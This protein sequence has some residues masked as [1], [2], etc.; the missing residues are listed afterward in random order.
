MKSEPTPSEVKDI[1]A[2]KKNNLIL[3]ENPVLRYL[4]FSALYVSEGTPI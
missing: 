4:T 2:F 3:S 1:E